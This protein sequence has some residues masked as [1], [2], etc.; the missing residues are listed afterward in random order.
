MISYFGIFII[1][2]VIFKLKGHI[3]ALEMTKNYLKLG[4]PDKD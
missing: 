4:C 3:I 1:Y 2:S